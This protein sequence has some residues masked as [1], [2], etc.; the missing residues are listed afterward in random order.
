MYVL[1]AMVNKCKEISLVFTPKCITID[2][3]VNEVWPLSQIIHCF[4]LT[5]TWYRN[6][7]KFDEATEY[8]NN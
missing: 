6:V 8:R 1:N 2:L 3:T 7:T 4:H 5:Q